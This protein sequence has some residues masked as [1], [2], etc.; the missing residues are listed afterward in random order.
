MHTSV[1][2]ATAAMTALLLFITVGLPAMIAANEAGE[3]DTLWQRQKDIVEA[4]IRAGIAADSPLGARVFHANLDDQALE[5]A[6]GDQYSITIKPVELSPH[7]AP[8]QLARME[9]L[10]DEDAA[11]RFEHITGAKNAAGVGVV[12]LCNGTYRVCIVASTPPGYPIPVFSPGGEAN[13]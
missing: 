5:W 2:I 13:V 8:Y 4:D 7:R 11:H 1:V 3:H 6:K 9:V 10:S 12:D